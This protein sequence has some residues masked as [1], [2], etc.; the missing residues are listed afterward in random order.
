MGG[1]GPC[2]LYGAG[3]HLKLQQ[4]PIPVNLRQ[5]TKEQSLQ[6]AVAFEAA[7]GEPTLAGVK[8]FERDDFRFRIRESAPPG[9]SKLV[10]N[11][12]KNAPGRVSNDRHSL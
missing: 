4:G 2:H 6:K 9:R 3:Y 7:I 12:R 11:G 8:P 5:M 1:D 10:R